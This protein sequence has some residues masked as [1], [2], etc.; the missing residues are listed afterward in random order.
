MVNETA[1]DTAEAT[2][3]TGYEYIEVGFS[4]GPIAD[5]IGVVIAGVTKD[6]ATDFDEGTVGGTTGGVGTTT[7]GVLEAVIGSAVSMGK[8]L[9]AKGAV[10]VAIVIV[11]LLLLLL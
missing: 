4:D 11:I 6:V 9:V 2:A 5:I 7:D 1:D 3:V 8:V 10:V